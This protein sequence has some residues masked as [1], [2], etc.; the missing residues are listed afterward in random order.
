MRRAGLSGALSAAALGLLLSGAAAPPAAL[1]SDVSEAWGVRFRHVNGAFGQK[2]LPETM[3]SGVAVLDYDGDGRQ[4]LLFANSTRFA[5]R[6]EAP[7]FAALYRNLGGGR[8]QDASLAAGLKLELYGMGVAVGDVDNDGDPDVYLT[9]V[10]G[11]RLLRNE[12]GRFRDVTRESGTGDA[13]FSTSA[14]FFDA[15]GDGR[16]DLY[17]GHYVD[18]SPATDL[19][20]SLDGRRKSYCTPESYK[21]QSGRL[22]RNLDGARFEEATERSG[23]LD[24][25]AKALGVVATDF[26]QD[27]LVDLFVSNDTQPNRLWRNRGGGR[28][29]DVGVTAG[30]AFSETGTARAGMGVDSADYDG[31]GR[32]G[33]IVGNFSNETLA[34][35]RNEGHGLFIDDAPQAGIARASLLTLTFGLFFF[36]YDLDGRPDIFAANGHVADEI[37]SVQPRVSYAQ[38]PHL[39][40]NLGGGRFEDVAP[41]GGPALARPVVGRGA[42]FGDL[43]GDGDLDVVVTTS[44]GPARVLR[45]DA[46]GGRQWLRVRLVGTACNRDGVGARVTAT[47]ADGRRIWLEARGGGSYLSQS[48]RPLTFGLGG[49]RRVATLEVRWPGGRVDT[50]RDVAAGREVVLREGT[51][52]QEAK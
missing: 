45:N 8:F 22:F 40:R 33:L 3:G 7:G 2:Y 23:L 26:D 1:F 4:D 24:P 37:Q 47:L 15:D 44:G 17:V 52:L 10:G 43:D 25:A 18:W 36:D 49:E 5:G 35:Y 39:F 21:G 6:P 41:G 12:G 29:E 14:A 20:C 13:G 31:S 27:G 19:R 50:A 38:P 11:N 32:P 30:V 28:F 46:S 42:A 51:G 48:E 34:L 16:L 9:A